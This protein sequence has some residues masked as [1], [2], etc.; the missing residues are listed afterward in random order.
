VRSRKSTY[1]DDPLPIAINREDH[2]P[3]ALRDEKR[4][5]AESGV[6]RQAI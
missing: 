3:A 5:K 6:R 2:V 1:R 4:N